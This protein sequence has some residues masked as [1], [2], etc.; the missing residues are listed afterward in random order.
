MSVISLTIVVKKSS[1]MAAAEAYD[2]AKELAQRADI[3]M[4]YISYYE[5]DSTTHE[6]QFEVPE[7]DV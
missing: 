1:P 6:F 7:S 3:D 2:E 4:E 5:I